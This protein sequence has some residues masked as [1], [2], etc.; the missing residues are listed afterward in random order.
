[1]IRRHKQDR[2]YLVVPN[3]LVRNKGL[4]LRDVGL[5]VFAL[6][7]P[8]DWKF[9]VSGLQ[10]LLPGVGR[11]SIRDS[12][13]RIEK[14]GY[15]RRIK[16]RGSDGKITGEIWILSDEPETDFPAT[17]FPATANSTQ[18]KYLRNRV[19]KKRKE[20]DSDTRDYGVCERSEIEWG[21][22]ML[23]LDA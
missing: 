6:S 10:A 20:G 2:E 3:A 7:L 1:M 12:L 9:S 17:D 13:R 4:K 15:L 16:Q 19:S 14:A 22:Y 18:T 8:D 23:R 21:G 11:D 5:L